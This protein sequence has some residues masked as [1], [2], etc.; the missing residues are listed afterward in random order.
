MA[1][2]YI[3]GSSRAILVAG[4]ILFVCLNINRS[5]ENKEVEFMI[6]KPIS[7]EKFV[8]GYLLGFFIVA[9]LILIPL[10]FTMILLTNSNKF[11]LLIWCAS[12]ASELLIIISFALLVSLIVRSAFVAIMASFGFYFLSRLM[13]VFLIAINLPQSLE[14]AKV[15]ALKTL[16]KIFSVLFPRLDL[17]GQSSWLNYGINDF[18]NLKIILWQS[19]IYIP[20]MIFMALHDFRKK[21]F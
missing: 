14:E 3:A 12:L 1:A 17:F 21:Q 13:G 4:M 19:I 2:A 9:I 7:R 18:S 11:G 5:F 10:A 20:L 8:L 15:N 6:S 16:L